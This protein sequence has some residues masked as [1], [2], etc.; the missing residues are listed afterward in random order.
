V[1]VTITAAESISHHRL[2]RY[3]QHPRL[4]ESLERGTMLHDG[5]H[6]VL[7]SI[8]SLLPQNTTPSPSPLHFLFY[9]PPVSPQRRL[10]P[11]LVERVSM[12]VML[13]MDPST[14]LMTNACNSHPILSQLVT[15]NN[16]QDSLARKDRNPTK[17]SNRVSYPVVFRRC[18]KSISFDAMYHLIFTRLAIHEHIYVGSHLDSKNGL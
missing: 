14:L 2:P 11:R 13:I 16:R 12:K 18:L 17:T 1:G 6:L 3:K 5:L 8:F 4:S 9:Q 15:I 10:P 7:V